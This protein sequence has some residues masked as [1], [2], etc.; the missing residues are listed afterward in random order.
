MT[1][2]PQIQRPLVDPE[3]E[4]AMSRRRTLRSVMW[5]GIALL[6]L[7]PLAIIAGSV[8]LAGLLVVLS[9]VLLST[10]LLLKRGI[11]LDPWRA[12]PDI[13]VDSLPSFGE[14]TVEP[15]VDLGPP[16]EHAPLNLPIG[17]G[18]S[19]AEAAEDLLRGG[20]HDAR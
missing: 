14:P 2:D 1:F 13:T 5:A 9:V 12:R 19:G 3:L 4:P 16:V 7:S 20:D 11:E 17:P 18:R 15:P 6:A 8:G 10:T